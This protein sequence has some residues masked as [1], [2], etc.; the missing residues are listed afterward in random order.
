MGC[1]SRHATFEVT[2][3]LL[4]SEVMLSITMKNTD[5]VW[6]KV[7]AWRKLS[8]VKEWSFYIDNW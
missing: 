3:E 5:D 7:I 1:G 6:K 8:E 4:I 2:S